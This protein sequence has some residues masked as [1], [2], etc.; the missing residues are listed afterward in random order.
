MEVLKVCFDPRWR[1]GFGQ[2]DGATLN[3]PLH[4]KLGRLDIEVGCN[5]CDDGVIHRAG[6]SVDVV[7]RRAVDGDCD[8]LSESVSC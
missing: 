3:S 4:A 2:G 5:G 7:A 6:V 1:D 8:V